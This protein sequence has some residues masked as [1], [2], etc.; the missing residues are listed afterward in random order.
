M[1]ESSKDH[2]RSLLPYQVILETHEGDY[3]TSSLAKRDVVVGGIAEK[4][5]EAATMAGAR[6][7]GDEN[8]RKVCN[9]CCLLFT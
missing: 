3:R 7:A 6:I 4:I 5:G 9:N 8:L 1:P 2:T